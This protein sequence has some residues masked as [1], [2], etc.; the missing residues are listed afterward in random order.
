MTKDQEHLVTLLIVKHGGFSGMVD[1]WL[2]DDA[3]LTEAEADA[4][5]AW[6]ATDQIKKPLNA[7]CKTEDGDRFVTLDFPLDKD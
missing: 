5:D 3:N 1:K 2:Y 4:I 7:S 6:L